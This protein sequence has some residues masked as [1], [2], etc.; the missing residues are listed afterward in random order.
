MQCHIL[1]RKY[2]PSLNLVA[3]SFFALSVL[4]LLGL[5]VLGLVPYVRP[6][7][8]SLLLF[9]TAKYLSFRII[10]PDSGT[11]S[12]RSSFCFRPW[13][14]FDCTHCQA[15]EGMVETSGEFVQDLRWQDLALESH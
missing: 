3:G 11:S 8:L 14:S 1:L 15:E 7:L 10:Q 5:V 12:A 13:P 2:N 9:T 4:V 6:S